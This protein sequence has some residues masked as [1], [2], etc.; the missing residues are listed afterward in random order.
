M[1]LI[2]VVYHVGR[3]ETSQERLGASRVEVATHFAG[4]LEVTS[5][6]RD[7]IFNWGKDRRNRDLRDRFPEAR[8]ITCAMHKMHASVFSEFLMSYTWRVVYLH[9][10][11]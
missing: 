3:E 5:G 1:R 6:C 7:V 9:Q 10:G 8:L 2:E 11:L 4:S